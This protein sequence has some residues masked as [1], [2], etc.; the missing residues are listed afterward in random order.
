LINVLN[1]A[2]ELQSS[3][4]IFKLFQGLTTRW[5]KKYLCWSTRFNHE[6]NNF[7]EMVLFRLLQ[8]LSTWYAG[9][10]Q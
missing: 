4:V 3:T 7:K 10:C 5:A 2:T 1:L 6:H 8:I 9:K